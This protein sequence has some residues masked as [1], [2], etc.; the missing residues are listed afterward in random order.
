MIKKIIF[1]DSFLVS[2]IM[3]YQACGVDIQTCL[4]NLDELKQQGLLPEDAQLII[5]AEPE[6]IGIHR[7][8]ITIE[9]KEERV[10]STDENNRL[11]SD[12]FKSIVDDMGFD[13]LEH[14]TSDQNNQSN[15]LNWINIFINMISILTI[16]GLS[17]L[18]P[19]SLLLTIGLTTLSFLTTAFTARH[20]LINFYYHL[21]NKNLINMETPITLG[22]LL[23]LAHTLYHSMTMPFTISFSMTFMNF[24]M[25]I[26]LIT[27]INVTDEM[28]RLVLNQSKKIHLKG[29]K[30][31]FPHMSDEYPCYTISMNEQEKLSQLMTM[32]FTDTVQFSQ[33]KINIL[34]DDN[35][36][37]HNKNTLKEGMVIK[38]K[39]G[40]CFPVDGIIISGNTLIDA[41]ILTGEPQQTKK[42]GDVAPAGS[43]N[44][45]QDVFIYATHDCYNSTVNQLLF[46][47]NRAKLENKSTKSNNKFTYLYATLIIIGIAASIL[48][49][50]ALGLLTVP[51]VLQNVTGILFAICPCTMAI[52][53]QLPKLLSIYQRHN[54]GIILRD[55]NLTEHTN[56]IHTIVFDKT[57][58]LTT[59]NSQV[60]ASQGISASL[61][62]R[63][64]LLEKQHGADHPIA[65][66][67]NH[68]YEA[69]NIEPS[70]IQDINNVSIDAKSRGLSALVQGKQLHIGNLDYLNDSNIRLPANLSTLVN[71]QLAKGYTPVYVAEDG[72]YQGAIFIKHEIRATV[73]AALTQLK[74]EGKK[75]IMLTGDSELSAT[76]FNQQNGNMFD[77]A[78]IHAKH[79]PQD[80]ENFLT[81]LMKTENIKPNGIWFVGDGLND[82]PCARVA[83]DAGGVSCSITS[84]EKAAFFTDISLDGSLDYLFQH[85]KLNQFL[86]HIIAQ[87][88]WLFAYGAVAFI[89]FIL[90]F[91][92]IGIAI[93]P[94]IPMLIMLSTT[95]FTLFNSYRV[96]FSIDNAQDKKVSWPRQWLASDLSIGLLVSASALLICGLLISTVTTGGLTIPAIVFTAGTATTISSVCMIVASTAF[97]AITFLGAAYLFTATWGNN[98]KE[99]RTIDSPS[100]APITSLDSTDTD[101]LQSNPRTVYPTT[102]NSSFKIPSSALRVP[103]PQAWG[104]GE[105]E[106]PFASRIGATTEP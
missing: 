52:A 28:K 11:L 87:N 21:R 94:L 29:I 97:A 12:K 59:G 34:H 83:T 9:S 41:S 39:Q 77:P 33:L 46:R 8:F 24:I 44:L 19:P 1:Q 68:Y 64:Y 25:P 3:C 40:E 15:W 69:Q 56:E 32:P 74:K 66:A 78:N 96:Q 102:A 62:Q 84:D 6:S 71:A 101:D 54:K 2:G 98:P 23:S 88:Q 93:S 65:K 82:A 48:I 73:L 57:G 47:S 99:D 42:I 13:L 43:I 58:T 72:V 5:D 61:W 26:M 60:H 91:S 36:I 85:N 18:F 50:L 90:C 89:A 14:T 79:T 49:P 10:N 38:I 16:V 55:E 103:S 76:A 30:T 20:Y 53:H 106:E 75:L 7:L 27:I 95:L 92:I 37:H 4:S 70:V 17:V 45:S 67:I 80:K 100:Y 86:K 81:T 104:E 51:L 31:L 35:V 105:N 22:W 63:I